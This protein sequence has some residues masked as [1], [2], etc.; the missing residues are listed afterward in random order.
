M[1]KYIVR[2]K[3]EPFL[4]EGESFTKEQ[5]MAIFNFDESQFNEL[6][7]LYL[8]ECDTHYSATDAAWG[9]HVIIQKQG[10]KLTQK[11]IDYIKYMIQPVLDE[12][13][14]KIE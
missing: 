2:Y 11:E 8:E 7:S 3:V 4:K 6:R 10:V 1:K 12:I 9:G 14:S 13:N 5:W